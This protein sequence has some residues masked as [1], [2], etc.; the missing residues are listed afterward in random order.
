MTLTGGMVTLIKH[1]KMVPLLYIVF[2]KAME[3]KHVIEKA[4]LYIQRTPHSVEYILAAPVLFVFLFCELSVL[5]CRYKMFTKGDGIYL[6]QFIVISYKRTA[7]YVGNV[8]N[9]T[10]NDTLWQKGGFDMY[11]VNDYKISGNYPLMG[12]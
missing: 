5:G 7:V 3:I 12:A 4:N 8:N 1:L 10:W 2:W 11:I 6:F 9:C